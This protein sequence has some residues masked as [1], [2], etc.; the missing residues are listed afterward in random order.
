MAE[1]TIKLIDRGA[2]GREITVDLV[3]DPDALPH[4]HEKEHK[5]II[6]KLMGKGIIKGNDTV[7]VTRGNQPVARVEAQDLTSHE[8]GQTQTA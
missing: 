4:E 6:E 8:A 2:L 7:I 5:D 3:S 1:V